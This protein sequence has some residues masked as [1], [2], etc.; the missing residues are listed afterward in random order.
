V[1]DQWA[2]QFGPTIDP[3]EITA[4]RQSANPELTNTGYFSDPSKAEAKNIVSQVLA[5]TTLSD[6][7]K[8][9]K[10][11][12]QARQG[13]ITQAQLASLYGEQNPYAQTY[14]SGITNYINQA[15]AT[16]PDK[17]TFDE[18]G[19]IHKAATQ[20]G[21][22]AEDIAKYTGMNPKQA[23][24][25]FDVYNQGL[26][27][28][29]TGLNSSSA[30]DPEKAATYYQL[31]QKYGATDAELAKAMGGNT[32][33]DDVKRSLAPIQ[34]MSK[35]QEGDGN[36]MDNYRT[37]LEKAKATPELATMYAKEIAGIEKMQNISSFGE[38]SSN[39]QYQIVNPL[40]AKTLGKTEKQLEFTPED[41]TV[42]TKGITQVDA[43]N[44]SSGYIS[45]KPME[46]NGLKVYAN[47]DG[48]GKLTGYTSDQSDRLWINKKQSISGSW[49]ANGKPNPTGHQSKGGGLR[50][51][52]N[53]IMSDP[54]LGTLGN[55]AAAY[56][57]PV[58]IATLGLVQG[59]SPED[60]AKSMAISYAGGQIAQGT[61]GATAG[62]LG[63]FGS[64]AAGQF[65]GNVGAGILSGKDVDLNTA[66]INAGI[67][68]GMNT[69]GND[70][71][72][73]AG[74]DKLGVGQP[75]FTGIASN[76]LTSALTGKDPNIQ[77]AILNT[78]MKQA[79]SGNKTT[80]PAKVP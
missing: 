48:N 43:E 74:L 79:M 44:P 47:Y 27:S 34:A 49:D 14:K 13:N 1:V 58:G 77:N 8:T 12:D 32:T 78:A 16:D 65:A 69:Y 35:I 54:I 25:Y 5:D 71:L 42:K 45:E 57:G 7:E 22:T 30:T 21:M 52:V 33:A 66:L 15:L 31:Q 72:G 4:F 67:N 70:L 2:Q 64:Q 60:I 68:A 56:F 3:N 46:V 50:G 75:Y 39:Q 73:G 6:W 53:E 41:G 59:R 26:G 9:T 40:S 63:Q 24:A 80:Q 29:V 76:V 38:L 19:Q 17:T 11:M 23:Q 55:L 10:I 61:T 20:Y 37:F 62:S 18:L 28:I 36:I 51:Q